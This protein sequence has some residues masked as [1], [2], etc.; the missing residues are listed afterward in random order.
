MNTFKTLHTIGKKA[1]HLNG[2]IHLLDWDQETYLPPEGAG[3]RSEQVALI[4][5]MRHD[6][7]TSETYRQ[8]LE[9]FEPDTD[10]EKAC[11]REWM[12]DFKQ[13]IALPTAFVENFAKTTSEA[14]EIW[15]EA[16]Q[17]SDFSLFAPAL[18]K[19]VSL[20]RQKAEYLGYKETPYDAL[21]DL[22]EPDSTASSIQ[23]LFNDLKKEIIP[24]LKSIKK[25]ADKKLTGHFGQ[26]EQLAFSRKIAEKMGFSF[27]SGRLDLTTH[28][29]CTS[30]HPQDNRIT[31]RV[32]TEEPISCLMGVIHE[33]GH[34]LYDAGLPVEWF[35][36][37][38][39]EYISMGMQ[40]S[41]SR[42]WETRIGQSRPFWKGFYPELK[43]TF[44][45]QLQDISE[46]EFYQILNRVEPTFIR[47]E[48]DE[49]TYPLHVILRFE[50]EKALI[51][52]LLPVEEIP[53]LW[54]KKM[55]EYLGIVPPNDKLGCLQDVHWSMGG[56]GYFPTYT[57]GNMYAAILFDSFAKDHP[58]WE[59]RVGAGDL[60]FI[61]DWQKRSVYQY[62]R[63]Y[64]SKDLLEKISHTPFSAKPYIDYLKDK[65]QNHT[66]S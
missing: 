48:A 51:N 65:Y 20:S 39:G 64:R 19:V 29:F 28:P 62:G 4:S 23:I 44:S 49:V 30:L 50:I 60:S 42:F 24:L 66:P 54:N 21:L 6:L 61:N 15:K 59:K 3:P 22:Y 16:R 2:V 45:L 53:A 38:L 57:L 18:K 58:D 11:K 55:E 12:L 34:A 27:K 9:S 31:T 43:K 33:T 14:I 17:K 63:K 35:G 5:S 32:Y 7:L 37:P 13:A 40:E 10:N 36:T 46:E 47:V 41:Q 52:D 1:A 25:G 26:E 56:I 8:S